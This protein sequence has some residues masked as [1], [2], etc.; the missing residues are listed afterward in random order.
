MDELAAISKNREKWGDLISAAFAR[1]A[2][3]EIFRGFYL[4]SEIRIFAVH[5]LGRIG[6]VML[7]RVTNKCQPGIG[8]MI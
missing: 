2:L 3:Y 1:A 5:M 6:A 8:N 4:V 7:F